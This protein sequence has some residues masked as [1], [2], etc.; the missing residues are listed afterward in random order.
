MRREASTIRLIVW[1]A[2]MRIL[3]MNSR[4]ANMILLCL[5]AGCLLTASCKPPDAERRG[6]TSESR[7]SGESSETRRT[8]LSKELIIKAAN[9][10]ARRHG[11]D[12]DELYVEYDEGNSAWRGIARGPWP[13]LDGRDFQAVAYWHQP[14]Q[15]EGGLWVLV[16]R[17]T[18]EILSV[19]E[20]P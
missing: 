10:A 20:A 1:S 15:P 17:N 6:E 5:F 2:R 13:E 18:G 14:P 12:P 8:L 16:D 3:K 4:M 11:R 19:E 9:S 7:N